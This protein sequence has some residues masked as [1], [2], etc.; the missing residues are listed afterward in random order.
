MIDLVENLFYQHVVIASRDAAALSLI[1]A[2]ALFIAGKR[3][4]SAWRHGLWLLIAV[5]LLIP[6]LPSSALSWQSLIPSLHTETVSESIRI[7]PQTDAG[8]PLVRSA[9]DL[10]ETVTKRLFLTA[11]WMPILPLIWLSGLVLIL[12]VTWLQCWRFERRIRRLRALDDEA[13]NRVTE[14]LNQLVKEQKHHRSPAIMISEGVSSPVMMG[15]FRPRILMPPKLI[16]ELSDAEIRFVLRHELAHYQRCD[17]WTSW[18]L[19]ILRAVHWFN[20]FIWWAFHRTRIEAE[21][22]TDA[23]VMQSIG[24]AEATNYGE[25]LIRL[26]EQTFTKTKTPISGVI[27]VAESRRD[28]RKRISLIASFTG[29]RRRLP[30]AAAFGLFLAIATVGLTQAPKKEKE[31]AVPASTERTA[32]ILKR[33]LPKVEFSDHPLREVLKWL[34]SEFPTNGP[35]FVVDDKVDQSREITLVLSNVP[36]AEALRYSASLVSAEYRIDGDSIIISPASSKQAGAKSPVQKNGRAATKAGGFPFDSSPPRPK[37]ADPEEAPSEALLIY[38]W[39]VLPEKFAGRDIKEVLQSAGIAF[40]VGCAAV[41]NEKKNQLIV[42]QTKENCDK[43]DAWLSKTKMK[44]P[45]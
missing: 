30:T 4:P 41:F 11:P 23:R 26:L 36:I 15:I 5:R 35:T 3:I 34:E 6:V 12:G 27:G 9:V 40:P 45:E 8:S 2:L 20:P 17:V 19:A 28:L 38:S 42:R 14:L 37:K 24:Q 16:A 43:V 44:A 21:Y 39:K 10:D 13:T 22:A 18:L 7:L 1:I 31:S 33:S 32:N 29:K 25:M